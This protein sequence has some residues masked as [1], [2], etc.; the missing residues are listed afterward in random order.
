MNVKGLKARVKTSYFAML[1]G[2]ARGRCFGDIPMKN[3]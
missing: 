3:K 2:V 1:L